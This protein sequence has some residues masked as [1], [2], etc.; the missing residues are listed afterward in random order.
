WESS[1][2]RQRRRM[3]RAGSGR[4]K[5]AAPFFSLLPIRGILKLLDAAKKLVSRLLRPDGHQMSGFRAVIDVPVGNHRRYTDQIAFFPGMARALV[6]IEA[7]A[8]N[9]EQ[10][11]FEDVAMLAAP[12]ARR[13][14][15]R[16][17]IQSARRRFAPP[18]QVEFDFPL[19]RV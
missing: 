17:Q 10:E 19:P 8:A 1:G 7:A 18:I 13:D 11:L 14:F 4:V 6:Q 5:I 15:L 2:F 16:H 9:D 3:L 12:L